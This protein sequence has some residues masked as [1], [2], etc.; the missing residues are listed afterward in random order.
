[1]NE[2][3]RPRGC[4]FFGLSFSFER[5]IWPEPLPVHIC[6]FFYQL[7]V[8]PSGESAFLFAELFD[9]FCLP[10][11]EVRMTAEVCGGQGVDIQFADVQCVGEEPGGE[12]GIALFVDAIHFRQL[13]DGVESAQQFPVFHNPAGEGAAD[14]GDFLQGGRVGC[15]QFD[16]CSGWEFFCPDVWLILSVFSLLGKERF[17]YG[18]FSSPSDVI[19]IPFGWILFPF[20]KCLFR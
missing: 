18:Y 16:N 3:G 2:K 11:V 19:R 12:D 5:Q 17:L 6:K 10:V 13:A 1:L 14:A 7:Q 8:L 20:R 15:I 4:P 9:G